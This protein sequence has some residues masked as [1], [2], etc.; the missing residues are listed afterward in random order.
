MSVCTEDHDENMETQ[1]G[2]VVQ[3]LEVS[4]LSTTQ[5]IVRRGLTMF[6]ALALL[7][8]GASVHFLVPL[9]ETLHSEANFTLNWMN[10]T[11][12]P[13]QIFTTALVPMEESD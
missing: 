6:A 13:D 7:A 10:T 8:V 2:H 9:P 12:T 3:Q 5:L 1:G 4:R 11:Y